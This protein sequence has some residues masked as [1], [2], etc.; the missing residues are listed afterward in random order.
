MSARRVLTMAAIIGDA[1]GGLQRIYDTFTHG[2]G[3]R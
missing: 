1:H 3:L 2:Q